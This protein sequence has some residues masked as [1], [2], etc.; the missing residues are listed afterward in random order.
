ML[1]KAYWK[2]ISKKIIATG[3]ELGFN[4]VGISDTVINQNQG[5]YKEWIDA[6][7]PRFSF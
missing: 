4:D 1:D 2:D 5:L 6:K 7:S 3:K